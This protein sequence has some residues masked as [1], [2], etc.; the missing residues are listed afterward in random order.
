MIG[1]VGGA[2]ASFRTP[3]NEGK[4]KIIQK[5]PTTGQMRESFV[6]PNSIKNNSSKGDTVDIQNKLFGK[7]IISGSSNGVNYTITQTPH[8]LGKK[9]FTG[10]INGKESSFTIDDNLAKPTTITGT[11]GGKNIDLSIKKS[12]FGKSKIY[13]QYGDEVI[14]LKLS[15][16][17]GKYTYIGENTNCTINPKGW[18]A[19][20]KSK[21]KFGLNSEILPVLQAYT[22]TRVDEE[23]TE[24]G[25]LIAMS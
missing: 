22:K 14:D 3:Y 18:S 1:N 7:D 19:D 5:D 16:S 25:A 17:W 9:E 10:V 23:N 6:T 12:L 8:L 15:K 24:A 13:G 21:G 2:K 4:I 11:I 20:L